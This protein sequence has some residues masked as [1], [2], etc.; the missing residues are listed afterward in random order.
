MSEPSDDGSILEAASWE[1]WLAL[2]AYQLPQKAKRAKMQSALFA[3]TQHHSKNCSPY[4]NFLSVLHND[5]LVNDPSSTGFPPALTA[6]QFK[7]QKLSSV[8]AADEIKLMTSSGTSSAQVSQIVLDKVTAKRQQQVLSAIMREWLGSSR[9]PM[10]ILDHP[11]VVR[12]GH[13]FSARGAGIQGFMLFGRHYC[14]ALNEDMTLNHQ[15]VLQFFEQHRGADILM[16]GFTYMAWQFVLQPLLTN[17]E[18]R[19][20]IGY[21]RGKL[22]HGGGWK[23]L[24]NQ[25]V[26]NEHFMQSVRDCFEGVTAHNYYGMVE[27]TGSIHVACEYGHLHAPVWADVDVLHPQLKTQ[28]PIGEQGVIQVS[29]VLPLSYP[30][31]VILTEDLGTILGEDDCPCGRKG[32]YFSVDGRVQQSEVRGCSDTFDNAENQSGSVEFAIST[33]KTE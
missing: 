26:S 3:L 30:G 29:S 14:Y 10:L 8:D 25:A 17:D 16:F 4:K 27:Q 32:R 2:P 15:A 19:S 11:S 5:F 31:H 12:R 28:Q 13:D 24:Q 20:Q 21:V 9:L 23:K 22:F 6:R 7:Y 18:L 1:E 33:F